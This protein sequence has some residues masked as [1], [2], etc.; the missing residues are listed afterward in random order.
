MIKKDY[1]Y[2]QGSA[3]KQLQPNIEIE[4]Q[5]QY[6]VYEENTVLKEKKRYKS[7]RKV[8]F[9]L[10]L[11]ILF[12]FFAG[13]TVMYRFAVITQLSYDLNRMEQQYNTLRNENSIL[14][15]QVETN[16]DLGEIKEIAETRLGMQKPDK[17]QIVYIKVPRNDYTVVLNTTE[18]AGGEDDNFFKTF[19]KRIAGLIRLYE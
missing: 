18:K 1:E 5:I 6:D 3:A 11:S 15:V 4:R 10:V 14:R 2:I 13:L 17:S 12:I 16:T 8:K 7:N 9:R 19:T